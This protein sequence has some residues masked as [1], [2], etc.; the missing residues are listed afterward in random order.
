LQIYIGNEQDM[1]DGVICVLFLVDLVI[2]GFGDL[3]LHSDMLGSNKQIT[4]ST[5]P[6]FK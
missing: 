5:N 1:F 6:H 2:R 3:K 4:A